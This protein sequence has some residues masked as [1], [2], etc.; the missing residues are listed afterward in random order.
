MAGMNEESLEQTALESFC[1]I[2][3]SYV[4]SPQIASTTKPR[5]RVATARRCTVGGLRAVRS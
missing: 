5:S 4:P 1:A 2:G 3:Y